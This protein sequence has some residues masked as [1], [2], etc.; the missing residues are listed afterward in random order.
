MK[1]IRVQLICVG[2]MR[3]KFYIDAAAEYVKRLSAYCKLQVVE[4]PEERL[5]EHPSA[6]Q[7]A[8][9]LEREGNALLSRIPSGA[10]V[11][12]LCIEGASL[13][14]VELSE[15]IERLAAGGAGE[16]VFV[17]GSSYGL[18][19]AVKQRAGLRLSMSAMTF[20]HQLARVMLLEQLYRAMRIAQGG[21]YHK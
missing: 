10:M 12:S 20:P 18:S 4:L 14:S 16:L 8:A 9:A 11:I 3:E 5:P 6:A 7:I 19:P 1:G 2:K 17:I 21:T 13:T 15:R